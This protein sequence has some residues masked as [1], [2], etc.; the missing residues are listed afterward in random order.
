[1]RMMEVF[2]THKLY[3]AIDTGVVELEQRA[4]PNGKTEWRIVRF[5]PKHERPYTSTHV[6]TTGLVRPQETKLGG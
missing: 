2:V 6:E 1:M 3:K 4:M 5:L